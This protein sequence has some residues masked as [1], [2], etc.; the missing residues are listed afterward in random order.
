MVRR[1]GSARIVRRAALV[2]TV[3]LLGC[4]GAAPHKPTAP[5]KPASK[6]SAQADCK[7]MVNELQTTTRHVVFDAGPRL[8]ALQLARG[9]R[10]NARIVQV[11]RRRL[12]Q[13]SGGSAVTQAL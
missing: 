2:L 5:H 12:T 13:A 10:A 11:T 7:N 8:A 9:A 3:G 6:Q 4:G 1:H